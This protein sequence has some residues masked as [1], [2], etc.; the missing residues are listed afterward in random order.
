M[1]LSF[2]LFEFDDM[3]LLSFDYKTV[4]S[5]RE[6]VTRFTHSTVYK[7]VKI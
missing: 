6:K 5:F 1:R 4:T 7:T 3:K 2:K